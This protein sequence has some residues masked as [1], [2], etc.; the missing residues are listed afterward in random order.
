VAPKIT[1]FWIFKEPSPIILALQFNRMEI[2][3]TPETA[4]APSERTRIRRIPTNAAYDTATLHAIVDATCATSL[5]PMSRAR[6]ASH[7]GAG[8][9]MTTCTSTARM[10]AACS[11]A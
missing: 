10:A 5:L 3:T 1:Q 8:A 11:S 9:K 4:A 6:T 2:M 7:G